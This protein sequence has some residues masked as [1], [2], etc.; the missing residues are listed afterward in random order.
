M[1]REYAVEPSLIAD[2][3]SAR[4][5]LEKFGFD[6]GRILAQFPKSWL[7]IVYDSLRCKPVEKKKVEMLLARVKSGAL[8]RRPGSVFD[9][10]RSWL[11]QALEEDARAATMAFAAILA[12]GVERPPKVANGHVIDE[13]DHRWVAA[14]DRVVPRTAKEMAH[15]THLLLCVSTHVRFIDPYFDGS[16]RDRTEP[17]LAFIASAMS[18]SR[19]H[20]APVF[21]IHA[22][23]PNDKSAGFIR[24][25]LRQF[26]ARLPADVSVTFTQWAERP[27]GDQFHN[28]YVLTDVGGAEFGAGLDQKLGQATDRVSLLS[29]AARKQLWSRFDPTSQTY[30][31]DGVPTALSND[32]GTWRSR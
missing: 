21:E 2:Y 4:Y 26:A 28:R 1:L 17:I 29:V 19:N 9:P 5:F 13:S 15:A 30:L 8:A 31:M 14:T 12:D 22:A 11:E 6:R 7:R 20:S 24:E 23:N 27:G 25:G 18:S 32:P 3:A 16:R 10:A